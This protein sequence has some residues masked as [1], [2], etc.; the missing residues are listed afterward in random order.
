MSDKEK[1]GVLFIPVVDPDTVKAFAEPPDP[2]LDRLNKVIK[3]LLN[4]LKRQYGDADYRRAY[5]HLLAIELVDGL[6]SQDGDG[7][8]HVINNWLRAIRDGDGPVIQLVLMT[9]EAADQLRGAERA[10]RYN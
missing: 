1:K 10:R 3:R 4:D 8:L 2:K 9:E 6:Y 7:F 5:A